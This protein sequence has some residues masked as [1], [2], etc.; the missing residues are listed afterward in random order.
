MKIYFHGNCQAAALARMVQEVIPSGEITA[1]E[2]HIEE[3]F[4]DRAAY[5]H[6]IKT[7]DA[8]VAQ[9]IRADYQGGFEKSLEFVRREARPGV[10]I[11]T[12]PSIYFDGQLP[13]WSYLRQGGETLPPYR[14]DYHNLFAFQA[15]LLREN[16]DAFITRVLNPALYSR[17]LI[18][19]SLERSLI[20]LASRERELKTDIIVSDLLR[21][22]CRR[23][24][25]MSTINHPRRELLAACVNRLLRKLGR[26]EEVASDGAEYLAF[27]KIPVLPAVA[28]FLAAG[29]EG[30]VTP[31]FRFSDREEGGQ[32]QE[33]FYRGAYAHYASLPESQLVAAYRKNRD[34]RVFLS[35]VALQRSSWL[36]QKWGHLQ[37]YLHGE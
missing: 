9:P 34:A 3:Q 10:P 30:E 29:N 21:Q 24:Q 22:D 27:P 4:E 31:E 17:R 13:E 23:W 28:E 36:R 15:A 16:V 7:A 33:A 26:T 6:D 20:S 5:L 35:S 18:E 25:V 32:S 2:I 37:A 11:V 19:V 1:R 8:I 14:M 12:F